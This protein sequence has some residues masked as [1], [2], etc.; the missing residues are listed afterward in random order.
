[1][2]KFSLFYIFLY[3]PRIQSDHTGQKIEYNRAELR[4]LL[5][6]TLTATLLSC[7][8]KHTVY[9][10]VLCVPFVFA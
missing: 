9:G 6:P 7:I 5:V 4:V 1:M 2:R 8:G 3:S 10:K